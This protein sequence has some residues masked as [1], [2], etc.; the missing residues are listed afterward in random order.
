MNVDMTD[1][2]PS[3]TGINETKS[4]SVCRHGV[5]R[6]KELENLP[7]VNFFFTAILKC[8]RLKIVLKNVKLALWFSKIPRPSASLKRSFCLS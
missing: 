1:R 7:V 5:G 3:Y 2:A 6:M 4:T 8:V